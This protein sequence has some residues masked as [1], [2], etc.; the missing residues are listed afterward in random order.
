[1]EAAA[2]N[3][4]TRPL[5]EPFSP[6]PGRR[7]IIGMVRSD[8][9]SI[10]HGTAAGTERTFTLQAFEPALE[11]ALIAGD[12]LEMAIEPYFIHF[13]IISHLWTASRKTSAI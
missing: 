7:F 12:A 11:T 3:S 13:S 2:A 8:V 5:R 4:K 6:R 9:E 1:M 10:E